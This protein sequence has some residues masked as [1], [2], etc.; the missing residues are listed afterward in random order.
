MILSLRVFNMGLFGDKIKVKKRRG[1][2]YA[3][4]EAKGPYDKIP[5]DECMCKLTA[6]AK[7]SRAGIRGGPFVIY[8]SDPKVTAP[9]DLLTK[10]AIPIGKVVPPSG[11]TLVDT[12]PDMEVASMDHNAP[13]EEYDRS[14]AELAK[15][16]GDNGYEPSGPP[17]EIYTAK[18]KVKDGKTIIYSEIQFPV[19]KI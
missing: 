8:A 11:G 1:G 18:P 4:I 14:Y 6:W 2:P 12:L 7:E 16:I 3:Y 10:V 9:S 15:W 17:I 5:F 19:K 13:A